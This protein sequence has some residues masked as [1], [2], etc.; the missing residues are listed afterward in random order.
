M[1]CV[2]ANK[3]GILVEIRNLCYCKQSRD[4]EIRDLCYCKQSRDIGGNSRLVLLQTKSGYWWKF[5]TCV[6][7]N[8][9]GMWKFVTCVTANKV[10][11]L[12]EIRDLCYCKQSQDIAGKRCYSCCKQSQDSVWN[13]VC[14]PLRV[15]TKGVLYQIVCVY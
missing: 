8:K 14:K 12:V 11:I 1:T 3:V 6:T 10:G 7:A 5:V 4:V 13:A 9:V 2:T 15:C